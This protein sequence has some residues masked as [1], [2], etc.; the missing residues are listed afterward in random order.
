MTEKRYSD[1][2]YFRFLQK[3]KMGLASGANVANVY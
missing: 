3:L 1:E 2:D